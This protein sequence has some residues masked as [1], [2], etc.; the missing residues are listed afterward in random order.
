[1][2]S[3]VPPQGRWSATYWENALGA[4]FLAERFRGSPGELLKLHKFSTPE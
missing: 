2:L 1:M 4:G 3:P